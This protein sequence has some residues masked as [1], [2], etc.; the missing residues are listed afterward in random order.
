MSPWGEETS[1]QF[2]TAT[3]LLEHGL[4]SETPVQ[5]G[6]DCRGQTWPTDPSQLTEA[7]SVWTA[8]TLDRV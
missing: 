5:R 6:S 8:G 4:C 2:L 7:T 1:L 3:H